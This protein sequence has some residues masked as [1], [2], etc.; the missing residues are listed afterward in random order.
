MRCVLSPVFWLVGFACGLAPPAK[1]QTPKESRPQAGE[2]LLVAGRFLH[3]PGP[4]PLLVHGK[5]GAWDDG[6]IEA[7][8]AIEDDGKFYFYYHGTGQGRAYRLGVAV[9]SAP[10]GPFEKHG[11]GPILDLGPRGS[12]DDT[13]VACAMVLKEG[14]RSYR[15]WYSGTGAGQKSPHWSIG[16]A[17]APHPLGPWTKHPGNPILNDFGYVGGVVKTRGKYHLYCA[18]PIGSTGPDYSPMALAT[19]EAPEGPWTR[20]SRNPVLEPGPKDA[21]DDGGFSEAEVF[22]A[23]GG[24]HMFYGGAKIDP[25]RIRTRESIGYAYSAD[26]IAF[27]KYPHNPV[28][29]R[30]AY[31]NSA[32]FAEVHAIHRPPLVFLY[33]T[34]RYLEPRT[35]ED[36]KRF[37]TIEDL[38]VEVLVTARPF[39]LE[40]P[41]L[42]CARLGPKTITDSLDSRP[43]ALT[44]ADRVRLAVKC[45]YAPKATAA[46]RVHLEASDD[47]R[48]WKPHKTPH[49]DV[50]LCPGSTSQDHTDL[51]DKPRL[52]RIRAENPNPSAEI[53][54]VAITAILEGH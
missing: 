35:P 20:W 44:E 51:Q 33:H 24:F 7:A 31:P 37:P 36:R 6:V 13:N 39:R 16:L 19:A 27:R 54:D 28:A 38:G 26:G 48:H 4:N 47:G 43:L 2:S 29:P 9:A 53:I 23:N 52:L 50:R 8:D 17:T 32:A 41:A 12:W 34:L 40:M 5:P 46:L 45:T 30:E 15:M 22:M 49:F 42:H 10:L 3:I 21:W 1:A 25:V 14:E 18:Y 11:K